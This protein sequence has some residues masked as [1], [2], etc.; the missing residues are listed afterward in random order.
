MANTKSKYKDNRK[1]FFFLNQVH[2]GSKN[3]QEDL[4]AFRQRFTSC[5]EWVAHSVTISEAEFYLRGKNLHLVKVDR[6]ESCRHLKE[7]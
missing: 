1:T 5:S 4:R 6:L 2:A 7:K 3:I